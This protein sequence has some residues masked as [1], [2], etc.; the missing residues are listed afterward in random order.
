MLDINLN[1]L[2]IIETTLN[3][4]NFLIYKIISNLINFN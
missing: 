4:N 2:L 3:N 1:F